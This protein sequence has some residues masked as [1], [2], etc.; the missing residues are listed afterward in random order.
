MTWRVAVDVGGTF[1]DLVAWDEAERSMVT[2]KVLSIPS[3]PVRGVVAALE[4]S[5]LDLRRTGAFVHGSTIAINAVLQGTGAVTALAT[6]RGFRDV[7]E[8]GRKNRPDMYN[9]FFRPRMCPVPRR[10][11]V[12]VDERLDRNGV[13][14]RP[15]KEEQVEATVASLPSGVE[16][17]AIC[18]LHS[19]SNPAHETRVAAIASARRPDLYICVSSELSQEVGEFERSA[20]AALNAYVGPL[21]A[22]YLDRLAAHLDD[23]RCDG[24]L[25]ITQSNGGVM[26]PEVAARQPVRTVES[27]PAA[28]VTG[29]A[30]LGEQI[31]RRDLIAFDMGGTSAKAC[32]IE[33]GEPEMSPQ[34]FVGGKELG[35]P[36]QI[37]FLDIVEV[38]AGGGSIADL[39]AAGGLRVGPR[40]AGSAPGPAAY[41]LGGSDPTITDANVVLGRISPDYFLGGEMKLHADRAWAAVERLGGSLGLGPTE[42]ALGILRVANTIMAAAIRSVTIERGRDPR[43]LTLVAFGGAGPVHACSLAAELRVPEVLVPAG[44]GTFAAF[45]MLETDLRHDVARTFGGRLDELTD[46]EVEAAFRELE[47]H[48]LGYLRS[49][50]RSGD[51]EVSYHRKLDLRYVGQFHPLTLAVPAGVSTSKDVPDRFHRAHAQRYGHHAQ[52]QPIEVGA[53]RVRAVAEV[54]KPLAYESVSGPRPEGAAPS[55]PVTFDDGEQVDCVVHRRASLSVGGTLNG[56]AIVEDLTTNIVL[57]PRD[58]AEV[59]RGGH[60]RI[61]IGGSPA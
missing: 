33:D 28:G 55:R 34:Y 59:L 47:V 37:P 48:A 61:A 39:D 52:D 25:L 56:P 38:G 35:L 30:W 17:L 2:A 11:R 40:S 57:G 58:S 3:D 42:C 10:L 45:G 50:L 29:A 46:E 23:Q 9:L 13:V 60:L 43:D 24:R 4:H 1:T 5:G 31:G 12:E 32:V 18:L 36:V 41:G 21:V 51:Q 16:S 22:G 7:L 19:Y 54:V 20:T 49:E 26:T 27:G 6:T 44:A 15:L 8:M 53:L 14:V